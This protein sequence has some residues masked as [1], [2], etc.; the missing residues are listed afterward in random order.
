VAAAGDRGLEKDLTKERS[1][2]RALRKVYAS[3]WND[4]AFEERA[5]RGVDHRAAFM[6]VA[7]DAS[8]VLEKLDAVAVTQLDGGAAGPLYRVVSQRGGEGVV[9]PTDPTSV[10]ETLTFHRGPGDTVTGVELVTHSSLSPLPLWSEAQIAQL[11]A[12]LFLV[13]DHFAAQ[14]YPMTMPLSLDTEIKLTR[15]DRIVIKQARPYVQ[16]TGATP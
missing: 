14:V 13:H 7:V 5:Y 10:A 1:V 4:R 3:L 2:T 8:F 11:G 12:L 6:G 16:P 15:D 9:R